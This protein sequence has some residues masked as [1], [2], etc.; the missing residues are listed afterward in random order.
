MKSIKLSSVKLALSIFICLFAFDSIGQTPYIIIGDTTVCPAV[1]MNSSITIQKIYDVYTLFSIDI[2]NNKLPD[3]IFK[4]YTTWSKYEMTSHTKFFVTSEDSV[5]FAWN[6][7]YPNSLMLH[8][9]N[10]NDTLYA[11]S[12]KHPT[13]NFAWYTGFIQDSYYWVGTYYAGIKKRVNNISYLG[14]LKVDIQNTDVTILEYAIQK[15]PVGINELHETTASLYPNPS[16][17]LLNI[18]GI[19]CKKIEIY[20]ALG[21]VVLAEENKNNASLFSVNIQGLEPGMYFTKI[22]EQGKEGYGVKKFIKQ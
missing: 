15:L 21:A 2:D 16:S 19:N 5:L 6:K 11:D 1:T 18:S 13:G 22:T 17:D 20:N 9:Y 8:D 10:F 14:W 7:Q 12:C 3:F 4:T